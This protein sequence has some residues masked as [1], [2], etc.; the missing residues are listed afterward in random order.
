MPENFYLIVFQVTIEKS[1]E[2]KV[3]GIKSLK[4]NF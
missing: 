3:E 2:G 1:E 4:Y